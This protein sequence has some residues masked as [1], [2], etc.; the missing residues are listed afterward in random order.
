ME[1]IESITRLTRDLAAASK[2]LS[3]D[4]ARFLV[5]AYYTMQENRKAAGNQVRSLGESAEPHSVLNWLY[6]NQNTL[7]VQIKR[8]LD[9]Y[10]DAQELSQW[11]KSIVGIGPVISAGLLAHINIEKAHTAHCIW[12]FAGLDPARSWQK[13]QKRPW[14]AT[15]KTLCWKIGESFVKVSGNEN[16]FYGKWYLKRKDIELH[17]N[18]Q[19]LYAQQAK[20]KL[21]RFKIGP[22][23]EAYKFYISGQLPPAHI[24]ARAKRWAVKLFLSH[25]YEVGRTLAGLPVQRPYAFNV[26]KHDDSSY[27]APPNWTAATGSITTERVQ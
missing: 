21:E 7:E 24:H 16:D 1:Q 8:A 20:E 27:I 6:E 11:A 12:A 10:T 2:T 23:T 9:R 4:E 22:S 14:N 17:N 26:L 18:A 25:Y 19:G 13:G 3:D 15:L 5:D